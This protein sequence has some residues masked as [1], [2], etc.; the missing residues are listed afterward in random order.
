MKSL[1]I[2]DC[3]NLAYRSFFS[4]KNLSI[5]E[6]KIGVIFGFLNQL[7][8]LKEKVTSAG[9]PYDEIVFCWDSRKSFRKIIYPEYKKKR[10]SDKTEKE[11]IDLKIAYNQFN[12]LREE[13]LPK[14]G[15]K[16]IFM[17]I[18]FEADDIIAQ[19]VKDN[20]EKKIV[21]ISTDQDLWQVLPN[22]DTGHI[23]V[24]NYKIY[25][26]G[27]G[28][29]LTHGIKP[30]QWVSV[31]ALSGCSSDEVRGIKGVGEKTAIKWLL[32]G[33]KQ[34]KVYDR[35]QEEEK[36]ILKT[37]LPIV[38][39]PYPLKK[40]KP[41]ILQE[42]ILYKDDFLDVFEELLFDSFLQKVKWGK[43]IEYFNLK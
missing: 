6:K 19:V 40:L 5:E 36:E 15:F 30:S 38:T 23:Q 25:Q 3:N 41:V 4:F 24:Y 13:I 21:V 34:G 26:T 31:K 11:I 29:F 33:L 1:M 10:H 12:E 18:G 37:N 27:T 42:S 39:L 20:I 8:N 22:G 2:I 35:I 14:L 43:W 28:I 16:N 32:G 7:L 9:K 17:E